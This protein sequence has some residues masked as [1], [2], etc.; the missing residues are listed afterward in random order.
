MDWYDGT[1]AGEVDLLSLERVEHPLPRRY[2]RS[3]FRLLCRYRRACSAVVAESWLGMALQIVQRAQAHVEEIH[4][5]QYGVHLAHDG[6][7]ALEVIV[8]VLVFT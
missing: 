6:R 8:F 4:Y 3:R 1:E 5:R 7:K 2:Y